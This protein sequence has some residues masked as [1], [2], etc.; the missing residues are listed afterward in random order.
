MTGTCWLA[1]KCLN[2][3]QVAEPFFWALFDITRQIQRMTSGRVAWALCR[4]PPPLYTFNYSKSSMG[5]LHMPD[6][7][8][9]TDKINAVLPNY[10]LRKEKKDCGAL[11]LSDFCQAEGQNVVILIKNLSQN[12]LGF[13]FPPYRMRKFCYPTFSPHSWQLDHTAPHTLL[14]E[15]GITAASTSFSN[16]Q[17]THLKQPEGNKSDQESADGARSSI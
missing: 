6:T 8:G 4:R 16:T 10:S 2:E 3:K 14:W 7:L 13:I 9:S 15:Y 11:W 12:G 17:S 1:V 5:G